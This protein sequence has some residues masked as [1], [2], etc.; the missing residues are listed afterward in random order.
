M[1]K[2]EILYCDNIFWGKKLKFCGNNLIFNGTQVR[3]KKAHKIQHGCLPPS[4]K[5]NTTS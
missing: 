1:T 5:I 2:N 3:L 4:W